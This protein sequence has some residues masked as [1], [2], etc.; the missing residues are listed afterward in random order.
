MKSVVAIV[1]PTAIGKSAL[2][3]KV[4]ERLN[5][6]IVNADSRQV[7][8]YMDIGTA[9]PSE[10]ERA[11]FP[12]HLFDIVDPDDEFSLAVYQSLAFKTIDEIHSRKKTPILVGG[13]GLYVW[14]VLEGWSIPEVPPNPSLRQELE[15]RAKSEGS[16]VLHR[17]LLDVDYKAAGQ[18]DYKNV[19]RVIRALEVCYS[20]GRKFSELRAKNPPD[21]RTKILG[22]TN[23]RGVLYNRIDM[24]IDQMIDAGLVE[25]VRGLLDRGYSPDLPSM[26]SLGYPEMGKYLNGE[27]NLPEAIQRMKYETHR[28]A[29]HQYSWF[30]VGDERIQ[31]FDSTEAALKKAVRAAGK[32]VPARDT[33]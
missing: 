2:A 31:W 5:G 32:S 16:R 1:G 22:L 26:S 15:A 30:R 25:E 18:I 17:E 27:I 6:E 3:L 7:Y 24:R 11:M 20:T 9:K 8:R 10:A 23:Y 21:Y 19:R 33:A 14:A 29:R 12:H 4:A 13:S 28:F